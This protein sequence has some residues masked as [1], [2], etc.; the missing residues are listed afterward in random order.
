MT[1]VKLLFPLSQIV[2]TFTW[3]FLIEEYEVSYVIGLLQVF[4][5]HFWFLFQTYKKIVLENR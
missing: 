4:T 2:H 1:S 3:M 5:I